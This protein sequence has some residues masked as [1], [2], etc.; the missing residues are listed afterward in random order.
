MNKLVLFLLLV[1]L[2]IIGCAGQGPITIS[3]FGSQPSVL[4]FNAA[5][6]SISAG[7]SSEL[8]WNVSGATTVSIDQGI[9]SVALTGT[10]AVAPV[11]TTIYTLTSPNAPGSTTATT[12][13]VVTGT[14]TPSPSPTPTP[15]PGG[16]PTVIYFMA[17]PPVMA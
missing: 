13:V 12:Q 15:T 8:S 16:W 1:P 2:L 14:P 11:P 9:G 6:S 4:S 5:P 7:D 3:T 17:N 10:R